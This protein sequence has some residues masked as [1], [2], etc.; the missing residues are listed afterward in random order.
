VVVREVGCGAEIPSGG[1]ARAGADFLLA[2]SQLRAVV[3][4]PQEALTI[5]HAS[6]GTLL[7]AAP[8]STGVDDLHEA[9]PLVGGGW[10]S[11]STFEVEEDG[12]LLRGTVVD[13]PEGPAEHAGEERE[14]R[15]RIRPDDPQLY[16][17]GADGLDVHGTAGAVWLDAASLFQSG[18]AVYAP[19]V[20]ES[21]DLGGVLRFDGAS[22]LLISDGVAAWSEL[23]PATR[24]IHGTAPDATDL[25]LYRGAVYVGK[26]PLDPL[27]GGDF[28]LRIPPDVTAVTAIGPGLPSAPSPPGEDMVLALGSPAELRVAL[29]W[30][31]AT[32][33]ETDLAVTADGHTSHVLVP[34]DGLTL[35]VAPGQIGLEVG[36]ALDLARTETTAEVGQE[37]AAIALTVRPAWDPGNRV[38]ASLG[39]I[40][41]RDRASREPAARTLRDA[42]A[43]G[44][45]FAVLSPSD[46]VAGASITDDPGRIAWR[47]GVR[48]R[49][50]DGWSIVSWPWS[51]NTK[52]AGWGA[53]DLAR[54]DPQEALQTATGASTRRFTV[55]DAGWL[56]V[57]APPWEHRF[58]PDFVALDPPLPAGPAATWTGWIGW[59][60]QGAALIPTGPVTWVDVAD[61]ALVGGTEIEAGLVRGAV[62]AGTGPVIDFTWNGAGPGEAQGPPAR[63]QLPA[64]LSLV[65][66][67]SIDRLEIFGEGGATVA[68]WDVDGDTALTPLLVGDPGRWVVAV[69]WTTNGGDWAVTGPIWLAPPG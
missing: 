20:P 63:P 23:S 66:A 28:D 64:E 53:P 12:L 69:G 21:D 33:R 27:L 3:R 60:D 38:A 43:E 39:R 47:N 6:G 37:G 35:L 56:A 49:H 54:L 34:P 52:R 29:V 11:L 61:P 9:I 55:V 36:G 48:S 4:G 17:E 14:I 41:D 26:V 31:G 51:D 25:K 44:F 5:L 18:G 15:W 16:L 50:P 59:L 10:L 22:A 13:L 24:R 68:S 45:A 46:A 58:L 1:D 62:V 65:G 19:D 30:D 40:T 42:T 2:N 57:A 67:G 8:W 32:P 7:D